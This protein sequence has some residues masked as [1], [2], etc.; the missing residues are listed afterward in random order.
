MKHNIIRICILFISILLIGKYVDA[1]EPIKGTKQ[2][3]DI[4]MDELGN[5]DITITMKLNAS[6]WDMFKRNAGNNTSN[7]KREVEKG[8]PKYYLKDFKYSEDQMERTYKLEMNALA[9]AYVD[10]N[11]KWRAELDSKDPDIMKINETQYKLDA[12]FSGPAGFIEQTMQ[13]YLPS[14]AKNSKIEKDSFG[15]AVLTYES[16]GGW[17]SLLFTGAGILLILAGAALIFLENRKSPVV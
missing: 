13:I 11:G 6:Q 12:N 14:N 1:Q 3:L 9:A 10:K 5:A 7:L 17:L 8:M 15:K 2:K 4:K 16:G